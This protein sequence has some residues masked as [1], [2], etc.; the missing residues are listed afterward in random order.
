MIVTYRMR[1]FAGVPRGGPQFDLYAHGGGISTGGMALFV[2]P[3]RLGN[4]RLR[5]R[6]DLAQLATGSIAASTYGAGGLDL[7]GPVDR[8]IQ[9]YYMAGR[10]GHYSAGAPSGFHAYWLGQTQ[11]DAAKEMAWGYQAYENLRQ[12]HRD[13]T[14]AAY[15]VFVRAIPGA[16]ATLGGTALQ[17]SFMV[18]VPAGP[19]D[20][21]RTA[22]RNT[23]AHEMGHMWIGGLTG[24]GTGGT[25]WFNE[26]M[27]VYYT[28]LLLMRAGLTTVDD[29]G[30]DLNASVSAYYANPYRNAS[31]DSLDRLGFSAGVGAGSAQNVPYA[32]GSLYF[33][34]MD[35]RIRAASGDTRRLDDVMLPLLAQRR[36]GVPLTPAMLIDA[37]VKEVGPAA[38]SAFDAVIIR[39][40][41]LEPHSNAFGPCF[42]RRIRTDTVAGT[43]ASGFQWVRVA[44]VPDTRCRAW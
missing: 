3:E 14:T 43:I 28:R 40:E 31:A 27:N 32:R 19:L 29:Y 5:V 16:T 35:A 24:G 12:F 21:A 8:I 20:T 25:T 17:N 6:W 37:F 11:F 41:T 23:I 39:G 42:E 26:G 1:P 38:R 22:P 36:S 13:T 9:A 44:S 2:V 4:V 33:A 10:L 30:R 34:D 18:G 7:A 15:H